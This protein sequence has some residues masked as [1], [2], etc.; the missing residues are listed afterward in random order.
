MECGMLGNYEEFK[1]CLE[2]GQCIF[3]S[4]REW[5]VCEMI[6]GLID[7][8]NIKEGSWRFS[9]DFF[10]VFLVVYKSRLSSESRDSVI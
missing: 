9:S 4:R 5:A 10:S 1:F 2:N 7:R 8:C 3:S 6:F